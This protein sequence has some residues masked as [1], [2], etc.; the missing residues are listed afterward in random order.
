M[1]I[2][3]EFPFYP[4][5]P[6]FKLNGREFERL[7]IFPNP[8]QYHTFLRKESETLRSWTALR[9]PARHSDEAYFAANIY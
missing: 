4:L 1:P 7:W 5:S 9:P 6:G 8:S 3:V 2:Q